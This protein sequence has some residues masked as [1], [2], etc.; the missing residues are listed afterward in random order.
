MDSNQGG[1][2]LSKTIDISSKKIEYDLKTDLIVITGQPEENEN[3]IVKIVLQ[4]NF[5]LVKQY[6]VTL[7]FT[8]PQ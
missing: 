1:Y 3:A 2:V 4:N 6:S 5:G 8:C 7:K